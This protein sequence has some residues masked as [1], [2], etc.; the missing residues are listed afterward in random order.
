MHTKYPREP[1]KIYATKQEIDKYSYRFGLMPSTKI[2]ES[3]AM[4]EM[5]KNQYLANLHDISTDIERMLLDP[6]FWYQQH[7]LN[8]DTHYLNR[9]LI[10]IVQQYKRGDVTRMEAYIELGALVYQHRSYKGIFALSTLIL[11]AIR[12]MHAD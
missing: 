12:I 8:S 11:A 5:F 4:M 1:I 7:T 6:E 3:Q 9:H 2:G 10:V